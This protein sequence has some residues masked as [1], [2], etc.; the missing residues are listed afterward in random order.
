MRDARPPGAYGGQA[1]GVSLVD[2]ERIGAGLRAVSP[3]ADLLR[4]ILGATPSA[5]ADGVDW[6]AL[7][8]GGP[9]AFLDSADPV[10]AALRELEPPRPRAWRATAR[11]AQIP[12]WGDWLFWLIL[13]GRGFGKTFTGANTLAE[14]AVR[15][16]GDYA[17]VA[18][19]FGDAR[20]IC[21]EEKRSGLLA[22]LA[23]DL[24][25]YN[26]SDYIVHVRGG[27]RIVLASA[28]AP[29]RL[30]G[31]NFSG[32][33]LDEL[34]SFGN[35][36]EVWGEALLPA[37]RIGRYPRVVITTTPRRGNAVLKELLERHGKGDPMVRVTRG[38][39]KDNLANLSEAFVAN[40]YKRYAGT[41]LGRQELEGELLD[42]VE[43]A[44]I[45]GA[46]VEATRILDPDQVPPLR[47]I[48]VGVDPS[49]TSETT[50]DQCGIV[51]V[52]L[53]DAPVGRPGAVEGD[54]LYFL[55]D[56]TLRAQ[57]EAWARRVLEVADEWSADA[58]V[59]ERNNGGD[60][61]ETMIRMV[62]RAEGRRTPRI[63]PVWASRGKLTRA[64]PVAGVWQQE[65]A[66]VVGAWPEYEDCWTGW[67]PGQGRSPDPL[68]A[69][70][71][72]SVNL[73]PELA[74]GRRGEVRLIA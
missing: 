18:P 3:E 17:L 70:V 67:V 31:Y 32:A 27:S 52:G 20:K 24:V 9:P 8:L 22:A 19:T 25:D 73:M 29:D 15:T 40:I 4:A 11:S 10:L 56:A 64:E 14:W 68:D 57:P 23:D 51:V 44:L 60:M 6:S 53:G 16:P 63:V 74:V 7:G 50:S 47:R 55:E 62:A 33:W 58:I 2:L 21:V 34:A 12:P 1:A 36:E 65:R 43:G 28:D 54:H 71:W 48:V 46:L 35:L 45:R 49:V 41:A 59:P 38:A 69:G 30:R 72:G 13:A 37:L 5:L 26:K 66:H 61:V 39:T 42:D